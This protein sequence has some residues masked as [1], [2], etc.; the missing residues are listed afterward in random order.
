VLERESSLAWATVVTNALHQR[1]VISSRELRRRVGPFVIECALGQEKDEPIRCLRLDHRPGRDEPFAPSLS[2][3]A[4]A[5][6]MG[7]PG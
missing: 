4:S 2:L 5:L 7:M 6:A 1:D 3:H